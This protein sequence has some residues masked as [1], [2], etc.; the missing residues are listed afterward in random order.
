MMDGRVKTLHP[1]I[2][3]GLLGRRGTDDEVMAAHGIR[4]IDLLVTNLYPFEEMA[5]KGLDLEKLV[6]YIDIGGPAL[7]R[8]AAKNYRDVTVITD[9]EDY[10]VVIDALSSG[11]ISESQKF[12]FAQKAFAKTAAYDAAISNYLHGIGKEFPDVYY[13]P[14]RERE[15]PPVRREPPPE[16]LGIREQGN[17]RDGA[18]PGKTD[19]V[20]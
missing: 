3:G 8:A 18:G 12:R 19:V 2:H 15:S 5:G 9:P 20:Q 4:P 14:V 11:G 16:S 7:I 17:C 1:R 13:G 6:E 10:Q